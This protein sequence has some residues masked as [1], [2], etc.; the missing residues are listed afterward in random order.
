MRKGGERI[1]EKKITYCCACAHL[2]ADR[3]IAPA[4]QAGD[5][6]AGDPRFM[7]RYDGELH[8]AMMVPE[9]AEA[10]LN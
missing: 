7:G 1:A 6:S 3:Q 5:D 2:H 8:G 4:K 9:L 10:V